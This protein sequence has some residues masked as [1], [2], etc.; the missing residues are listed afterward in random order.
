MKTPLALAC[1]AALLLASCGPKAAKVDDAR[2]VAADG[3]G[4]WLSYGKGYSEQRF[5]PLDKVNAGN[6]GQLGLAWFHEFDT[7]R[8]QEATPL[9][10]DGVLYT[11]TNWSKVYA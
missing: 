10:I 1:L 8:G 6:V 7:N 4:E 2:L 3:N 11:T 9:M 5:S